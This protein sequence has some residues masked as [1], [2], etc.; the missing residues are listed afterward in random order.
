MEQKL[1]KAIYENNKAFYKLASIVEL[2]DLSDIG[3]IL[4]NE[5]KEFYER[6]PK[7]TEV[8]Y[9]VVE[10]DLQHSYPRQASTLVAALDGVKGSTASVPNVMHSYAQTKLESIG[11]KLSEAIAGGH[12]DLVAELIDEYQFVSGGGLENEENRVYAKHSIHSIADA[13]TGHALVPLFPPSFSDQLDG[14]VVAGSH[15]LIFGRP[16]SGKTMMSITNCIGLLKEGYK[17]LYV[18]NEDPDEQMLLRLVC[19]LTGKSKHEVVTNPD[20]AEALA[21]QNGYENLVFAGLAPGTI[22]EIRKLLEEHQ[23]DVLFIDQLRNLNMFEANKV[24]QLEK[25]ALAART[26]GKQYGTT[27]FSVTQAG[28]SAENKLVLDMGDVDFSNTGIPSQ[29]DLMIGV[30]VD[31]YSRQH[32]SIML[33]VCKNKINGNYFHQGVFVNKKNSLIEE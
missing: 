30:G 31:E 19:A 1:L 33:S 6:D 14:G 27:I 24:L 12:D 32:D 2:E 9:D 28:D 22:P 20:R 23:P 3:Q 26:L 21:Y 29:M 5:A 7:A 11:H 10:K 16:D 8:D 4:F 15:I 17:V 13:T 25:A 18:G